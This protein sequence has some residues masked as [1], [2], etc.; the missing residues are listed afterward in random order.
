[1]KWAD[2]L[3]LAARELR[4]RPARSALTVAAVMLAA[5]LLVALLAVVTTART[6]VLS[7]ISKGG[8]LAAISVQPAEPNPGQ[9][10][11]DDPTP[12]PF[13]PITAAAVTALGACLT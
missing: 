10:T 3:T 9:E 4:R 2:A 12:G 1:M 8:A 7:Q 13:R 6:R 5:A 11:L